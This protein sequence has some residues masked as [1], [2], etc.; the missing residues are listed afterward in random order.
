MCY[1]ISFRTLRLKALRS[2]SVF[3]LSL[4]FAS[5]CG[6]L[7]PLELVISLRLALYLPVSPEL[8]SSQLSIWKK[9]LK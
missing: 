3:F 9:W 6:L 2:L 5:L 1:A 7:V 4:V 8:I